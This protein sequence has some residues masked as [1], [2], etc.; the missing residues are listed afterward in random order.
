MGIK[1]LPIVVY[2]HSSYSDVWPLIFGQI[3]KYHT[4]NPLYLFTNEKSYGGVTSIYYNESSNYNDRI[5]QCLSQINDEVFLFLHEDMPL[6][7]TPNYSVLDEYLKLIINDDLDSIKLI[8]AG[9]E[10]S[11]IPG[12]G[13]TQQYL[14]KNLTTT[15]WSHFSIQPTLIKKSTLLSVLERYPSNN[16]WELENN[17]HIS[18]FHPYIEQCTSLKGK[19]RGIYHFDSL[20]YPYTATAIVKG[21]WNFQEYPELRNLLDSYNIK[22]RNYND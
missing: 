15:D 6:Y 7:D 9:S 1:N 4:T 3:K 16:L 8:F 21:K 19:Q 17:I 5:T 10:T 22:S 2:S 20:V 18:N 12:K 14:Y 11:F 13:I